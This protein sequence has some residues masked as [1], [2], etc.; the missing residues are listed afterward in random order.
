MNTQDFPTLNWSST[1][2]WKLAGKPAF[3]CCATSDGAVTLSTLCPQNCRTMTIIDVVDNLSKVTHHNI[4]A[5]KPTRCG[6]HRATQPQFSCK[7][8]VGCRPCGDGPR[9]TR[10]RRKSSRR[11][12]STVLLNDDYHRWISDSEKQLFATSLNDLKTVIFTPSWSFIK[13]QRT[14]RLHEYRSVRW[15]IVGD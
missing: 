14:V 5:A 6:I 10:L 15:S 11:V 8:D 2:C 7:S 1:R 12:M 4:G 3:R 13:F 9:E